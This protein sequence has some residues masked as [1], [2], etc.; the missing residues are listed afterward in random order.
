MSVE[1][2][3]E[4]S[5]CFTNVAEV[6]LLYNSR[7]T[8]FKHQR[9]EN[10]TVAGIVGCFAAI[11]LGAY[12]L[13]GI[14]KKY[15]E[16][17]SYGEY[18]SNCSR[19]L[20]TGQTIDIV[21]RNGIVYQ[22]RGEAPLVG[23]D[24]VI[25][26]NRIH[27]IGAHPLNLQQY[28]ILKEIDASNCWVIP[29]LIDI[30][31]H[32][33]LEIEQFPALQESI[34]HGVTS[35]LVGNC[36]ISSTLGTEEELVSVFARV[37]NM[38][39]PTIQSWLKG[40]VTWDSPQTYYEHLQ[41]L[42]FGCNVATLIGHSAIRIKAMG[43]DRSLNVHVP[44]AE[45][46]RS[47]ETLVEQAMNSG[48]VGMSIDLLPW[49]RMTGK[50]AGISIPSQQARFSEYQV[51]SKIIRKHNAVLQATP[52]PV[53]RTSILRLFLQSASLLNSKPLRTTILAAMDPV[54]FPGLYRLSV[55]APSF[56]NRF[57]FADIRM[58]TLSVPFMLYG[59]GMLSPI[60]EELPTG[61]MLLNQTSSQA[62]K[63]LFKD[64]KFVEDFRR[65]WQTSYGFFHKNLALIEVV[66]VPDHPD[67]IGKSIKQIA[68]ELGQEP[69]DF[70]V[71]ALSTL[72]DALRWKTIMA[73]NIPENL[74][75]LL[76][77]PATFPGFNDSGAHSRNMAFYDGGLRLLQLAMKNPDWLSIE[78][79]V[80]R[81]TSEPAEWLGIDAGILDVG[82]YA[83]IAVI[84]PEKL[85]NGLH[86]PPEMVF[87]PNLGVERLVNR[88]DPS[89]VK[90]VLVSGKLALDETAKFHPDL[91]VSPFGR[92]L[93]R[94]R[95][96][97]G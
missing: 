11:G 33:D 35:V 74:K 58:Q 84:D 63:D 88:N 83:D 77:H 5:N 73:N 7:F 47:M 39:E 29:G 82:A 60:S 64:P 15:W 43:L 71:W 42:P 76:A 46:L 57:T 45:E 61:T 41:Q 70:F 95:G 10:N 30:H 25:M 37:E 27:S 86:D 59:D 6:D 50:Y 85:R 92:L 36:S 53:D 69:L 32:Y 56:F 20:P 49:H 91:G 28:Q 89:V 65:E 75:W 90:A 21:I 55:G 38:S 72:G 48:F 26:K 4:I 14:Q 13:R 8:F 79:A 31:C 54:A 22:G 96:I 62:R 40:K 81:I 67:W 34:R 94:R 12:V 18:I 23:Y 66:S 68:L 78:R 44:T 2:P 1:I 80:Q 97:N 24:V 51:L 52:S 19:E 93:T 16:R 3:Q 17:R 9:M 87:D